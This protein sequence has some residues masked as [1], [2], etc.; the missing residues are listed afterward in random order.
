MNPEWNNGWLTVL[1]LGVL[2]TCSLMRKYYAFLINHRASLSLILKT[3]CNFSGSDLL[4]SSLSL[5]V[6]WKLNSVN[7]KLIKTYRIA[8]FRVVL[9]AYFFRLDCNK[10]I[11]NFFTF[12]MAALI[13]WQD[14]VNLI[15]YKK[16]KSYFFS[17]WSSM[18]ELIKFSLLKI[19]TCFWISFKWQK[20]NSANCS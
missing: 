9:R 19:L 13:E 15:F 10:L 1:T 6:H 16:S 2:N 3:S 20:W 14:L 5:L 7:E 4:Y 17:L 8:L 11:F 18:S 12:V